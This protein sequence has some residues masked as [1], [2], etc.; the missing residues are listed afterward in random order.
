MVRAT[1]RAGRAQH[2]L[3]TRHFVIWQIPATRQPNRR[4]LVLEQKQSTSLESTEIDTSTM[5]IILNYAQLRFT[6]DDVD[7]T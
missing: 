5:T 4:L 7:V 1:D 2:V 3:H 6:I